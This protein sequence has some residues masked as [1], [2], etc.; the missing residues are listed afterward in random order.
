MVGGVALLGTRVTAA[1]IVRTTTR[2]EKNVLG[3]RLFLIFINMYV[4]SL[5]CSSESF[6]GRPLSPTQIRVLRTIVFPQRR[7]S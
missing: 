2:P 5:F 4:F 3:L 6:L 1:R 7:S